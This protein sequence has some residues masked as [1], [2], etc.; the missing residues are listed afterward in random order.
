MGVITYLLYA[1]AFKAIPNPSVNIRYLW[2]I[3]TN[4]WLVSGITIAF[5][6]TIGMQFIMHITGVQRTWFLGMAVGSLQAVAILVIIHAPMSRIHW[7]GVF[8]VIIGAMMIA[9]ESAE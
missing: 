7:F 4:P 1:R 3:C 9:T 2:D 6:G 5:A 8:I